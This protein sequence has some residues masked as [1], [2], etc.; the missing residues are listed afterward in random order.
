MAPTTLRQNPSKDDDS[1]R[2]TVPQDALLPPR[3]AKDPLLYGKLIKFTADAITLDMQRLPNNR[4]L[5]TDDR[6]KFILL[7]CGDLRFP[8]T[9]I[10]VTGDYISRLLKAGLFLNGVQ[11]RF[12]HHSNSQLVR[13]AFS[14]PLDFF[15]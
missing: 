13:F 6:S 1:W 7:S 9:P 12:Y 4:I 10:K 15:K 3:N 14:Y 8:E 5:Q 11:Y 2:F